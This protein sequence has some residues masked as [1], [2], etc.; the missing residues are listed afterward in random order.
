MSMEHKEQ[1]IDAKTGEI[2]WRDY[3][4]EEI[5][6]SEKA[7]LEHE[8]LKAELSFKQAEAAALKAA[9]LAKLGITEEEAK[10][11]MS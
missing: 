7:L 6:A 4:K 3:T 1:I 9:L 10:L 2:T 5:E 11:L 8:K